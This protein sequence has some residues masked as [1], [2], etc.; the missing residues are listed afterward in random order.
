LKKKLIILTHHELTKNNYN[1]LG[2]D[3]LKKKFNTKIFFVSNLSNEKLDKILKKN[4]NT[5]CFEVGIKFKSFLI[6]KK[7]KKYNLLHAS[8]YTLG[9]YPSVY[10]KKTLLQKLK[11]MLT[12]FSTPRILFYKI[13][14][15]IINN[16]KHFYYF[17]IVF[18]GGTESYK[19]PGF[20]KAKYK[21][22]A[23]SLDYGIYLK[24]KDKIK[25]STNQKNYAVF[26]DTY[27]P[28]HPDNEKDTNLFI[29]PS[30]YFEKLSY[31]LNE[32][33]KK[34]KLK[35]IIALH[36]K[37]DLKRY[38]QNIKKFKIIKNKT[39]SL[40]KNSK[41]VLHQGSTAQSYAVLFKKPLIFLT[42]N[43]MLKYDFI[44][45]HTFA[46]DL[47]KS[48]LMNMDDIDYDFLLDKKNYFI[49]IKLY[50]KIIF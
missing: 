46:K 39:I 8:G 45:D 17:D 7:I 2:I 21:I 28:F 38:P 50:I 9:S 37:A 33:E 48:K 47:F 32:F 49:I 11:L 27:F 36:P 44:K 10:G 30:E 6:K 29:K 4:R 22:Y 20:N 1:Q 25:I 31:F 14:D 40:I 24:N 12:L 43:E 3:F 42:S 19:Y 35:I 23:S 41:V 34:T 13:I 16:L 26:I 18:H 15:L 5:I